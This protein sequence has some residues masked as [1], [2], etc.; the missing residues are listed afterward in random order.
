[1]SSKI[2][3][4]KL[5]EKQIEKKIKIMKSHDLFSYE[6]K[7]SNLDTINRLIGNLETSLSEMVTIEGKN[8]DVTVRSG[9]QSMLNNSQSRIDNSYFGNNIRLSPEIVKSR[10]KNCYELEQLYINKHNEIISLFHSY[11]NIMKYLTNLVTTIIVILRSLTIHECITGLKDLKGKAKQ[12][13]NIDKAIGKQIN[14]TNKIQK[15]IT[16]NIQ[17]PSA[18]VRQFLNMSG[19]SIFGAEQESIYEI[20]KDFKMFEKK[21]K[22]FTTILESL[23]QAKRLISSATRYNSLKV[24][25]TSEWKDIDDGTLRY[26]N[27]DEDVT[28]S[29]DELRNNPT[30]EFVEANNNKVEKYLRNCSDLEVLY[31]KKHKEFINLAKAIKVSVRDVHTFYNH[32]IN[33]LA[34]FGDKECGTG[35]KFK[36]PRRG[37]ITIL[38]DLLNGQ[39]LIQNSIK[40][41]SQVTNKPVR[42]VRF[43]K[44]PYVFNNRSGNIIEGNNLFN[45][46]G[47]II[48]G[49][50]LF[51]RRLRN[52]DKNVT[53][54]T[55]H[56]GNSVF[57]RGKNTQKKKSKGPIVRNTAK[58]RARTKRIRNNLRTGRYNSKNQ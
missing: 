22:E 35:K 45:R 18:H 10:I 52:A 5:T 49:N 7:T 17:E 15:E 46:S 28:L 37:K 44:T 51:N 20:Q 8:T 12:I 6:N 36:I 47:N 40:N 57:Y 1:M 27:I 11:I 32:L 39:E 30:S 54:T 58:S 34:L 42:T 26:F 43:N 33:L 53:K 9:W 16:S 19:G 21:Q 2:T 41:L 14:I 31:I 29:T 25:S 4:F 13:I 48:E 24:K 55:N 38:D 56:R 3:Y 50:N 23:E